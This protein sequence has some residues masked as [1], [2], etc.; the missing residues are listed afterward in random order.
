MD[1]F[2]KYVSYEESKRN[3]I[4][5]NEAEIG[6][7]QSMGNKIKHF[8]SSSNA[9]SLTTV[10][11][12][13]LL[14]AGEYKVFESSMILTKNNWELSLSVLLTTGV[15]A[16]IAERAFQNPKATPN[17]QTIATIMW[18]LNIFTAGLF[19]F[20]SF[21]LAGKNLAYDITLLPGISFNIDGA[22]S[23]LFL[24]VSV[25]TIIEIF[26]YRA[27]SDLDIDVAAKRRMAKL[28]ETGRKADLDLAQ[29]R[30]EQDTEI[31]ISHERKLALVEDK[32]NTIQRLSDKYNGKVPNNVLEEVMSELTGVKI[33]KV[34]NLQL[35]APS[36]PS[37]VDKPV[38]QEQPKQKRAYH[39]KETPQTIPEQKEQSPENFT[40]GVPGESNLQTTTTEDW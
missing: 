2:E 29:A 26:A 9:T 15:S 8:F 11:F 37:H 36:Q 1:D 30:Q 18:V 7:F 32:L 10:L 4:K 38:I 31:K 5:E 34:E 20:I 35:P 6:F 22:S 13:T 19:G 24:L 16:A 12:Y 23:V 40:N 33:S 39:R 21:V 17:Q 3:K 14:C 28:Y 27:Y 25:L